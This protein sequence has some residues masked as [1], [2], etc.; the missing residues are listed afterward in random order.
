MKKVLL[1]E[2]GSIAVVN[3]LLV[4]SNGKEPIKEIDVTEKSFKEIE[5]IKNQL[6]K[7]F[8]DSKIKKAN[9]LVA[10]SDKKTL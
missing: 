3:N 6:T 5:V 7:S 8:K 4:T 2:N 1:F 10:V 9:N